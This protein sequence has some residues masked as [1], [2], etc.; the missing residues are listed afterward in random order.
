MFLIATFWSTCDLV[1]Q[2]KITLKEAYITEEG[3]P[4]P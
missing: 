1:E 3:R 2:I 4:F